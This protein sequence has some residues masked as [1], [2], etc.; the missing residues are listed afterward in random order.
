MNKDW[1]LRF[2]T[3]YR[4][5]KERYEK[6]KFMLYKYKNGLLDFQPNCS[7]ELLREQQRVMGEYLAIL[8]E[9]SV[10]EHINLN[11]VPDKQ[12]TEEDVMAYE[13]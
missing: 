13:V 8:E 10:I 1:I 5:T 6:L 9:R 7:Y 3:E 2:I 11:Y 12:E 4:E